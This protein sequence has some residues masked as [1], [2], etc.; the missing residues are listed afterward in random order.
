MHKAFAVTP[1]STLSTSSRT[2]ESAVIA[3]TMSRVW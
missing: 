3:S 1:P 2:P